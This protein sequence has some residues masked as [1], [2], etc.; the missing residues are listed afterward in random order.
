MNENKKATADGPA[1][2]EATPMENQPRSPA[3]RPTLLFVAGL[4][5][6]VGFYYGLDY[7][8]RTFTHQSTDDAFLQ[9]HVVAVAPRVAGQVQAVHV[10]DNQLVKQGDA[11]VELD[12]RDFEVRLAQKSDAVA[13]ANANLDSAQAG[14]VLMKARFETAEANQRQEKAHADSSRATAERAQADLKRAESLR[15]TGVLS[16]GE[17]DRVRADAES[18][19]ANLTA[20]EQ[21]ADAATSQVA[22][23]RAQVTLAGTMVEA[24]L[25]R[26]KQARSDQDAADLDLS[27]TKLGAPCDGRVTRKAVEPGDY[28][29]VGQS[30]LALV[31][32]NV[33]IVA[34][35]KET[36]LTHM[37][38]GQP[39]EI[40][41][42][43]YP[44]KVQ[45]GHV[46]SIMAGSG[47]SFSLLP[48][49]NAVG[50][51]VKVVQRVPVKIVF[52]E[53]LDSAMSLGPGMSVVP[54]VRVSGF[55]LPPVVL[56]A[57]ALVLA[58]LATL[59]LAR[60]IAHLR[61]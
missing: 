40:H 44:D 32:T 59:G 39:V 58:V 11:L 16:P 29:Q 41:L 35:F 8:V 31:P 61:D 48:P 25:T 43:A 17:F 10:E 38:S 14:L 36:Q 1:T 18:A 56:W 3:V 51:F 4:L 53:P 22:E 57:G 54:A 19:K 7:T 2:P 60:V 42:D 15:Q 52:N 55:T 12:P 24:A 33:W 5:L 20:A 34:N 50:N 9:A 46:D 13:A 45:R 6:T 47:A 37:R 21:K 30:L 49:E 27:Y 26:T 28:V 23:A